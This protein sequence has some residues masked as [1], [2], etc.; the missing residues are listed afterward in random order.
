MEQYS[1]VHA[2]I[3]LDAFEHNLDEIRRAIKKDTGIVA[4]IKTDGYGHGAVELAKIL[5][6]YEGVWG[7]AVA[8]AE[9]GCILR[10]HHMKKPILI[11]GYVFEDQYQEVIEHNISFTIFSYEDAEKISDLAVSMGKTAAIHIKLDTGMSRIGFAVTKEN[12]KQIARIASLPNLHIEGIFSHFARADETDK[13]HTL[14]Q[15]EAYNE[16]IAWLDGLGV[17]IPLHHVSNSAAI[18]DLPEYNMNLVRAG[19]ILYGLMPSDEVNKDNMDLKPLLSLRSRIVMVKEL[20]A[21]IPVSYGGT[22][23]TKGKEVIATVPVGYGDGYPRSLSNKG[24]VLVHGQRAPICGRVCM[25]QFMIDVTGISNVKPGDMVTLVGQD[26]ENRITME[27]VGELSGRF[28]YEFACDLGKR[29]PRIYY[30][31]GKK[32]GQRDWFEA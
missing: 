10:N 22:Y 21:G 4:V 31:D 11:L 27:E 24:Y 12:A 6:Q 18:M 23:Q 15:A 20:E 16:M 8:T 7:Y 2:D 30:R 5:E 13:K 28:N 1:R 9:E 3:D 32:V 26:G 19:I 25:D 29:I 14:K 17:A